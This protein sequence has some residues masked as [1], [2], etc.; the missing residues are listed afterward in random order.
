MRGGERG[1]SGHIPTVQGEAPSLVA[2]EVACCLLRVRAR[3]ADGGIHIFRPSRGRRGDR[4]SDSQTHRFPSRQRIPYP[5]PE[6]FSSRN[7]NLCHRSSTASH[8][9]RKAEGE[10]NPALTGAPDLGPVHDPEEGRAASAIHHPWP[11]PLRARPSPRVALRRGDFWG[12][13][14]GVVRDRQVPAA[15]CTPGSGTAKKESTAG[16]CLPRRQ[17]YSRAACPLREGHG[18]RL[19]LPICFTS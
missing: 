15:R 11:W 18:R 6:H 17:S 12:V 16:S 8:P 19:G 4:D 1:A 2:V 13:G 14:I 3:D 5:A 9:F 7:L 10:G